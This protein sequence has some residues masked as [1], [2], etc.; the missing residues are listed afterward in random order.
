MHFTWGSYALTQD[1]RKKQ[2]GFDFSLLSLISNLKKK[3]PNNFSW[4]SEPLQ[5][6]KDTKNA[7]GKAAW[8]LQFVPNAPLSQAHHQKQ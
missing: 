5:T 1:I 4:F 6:F 8:L 7:D 2:V 3:G